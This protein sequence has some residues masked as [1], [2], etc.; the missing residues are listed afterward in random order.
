MGTCLCNR[1][2][3]VSTPG[4]LMLEAIN[5][6]TFGLP[7]T[8]VYLLVISFLVELMFFLQEHWWGEVSLL[9]SIF[10]VLFL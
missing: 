1:T 5:K 6:G 3:V 7:L 2:G 8:A 4:I 10:N 9:N